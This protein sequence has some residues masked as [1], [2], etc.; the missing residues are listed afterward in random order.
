M[1]RYTRS[2]KANRPAAPTASSAG[3]SRV[4]SYRRRVGSHYCLIAHFLIGT[5]AIRNRRNPL[6]TKASA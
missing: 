5:S 6:I 4:A 1:K 2:S 3:R